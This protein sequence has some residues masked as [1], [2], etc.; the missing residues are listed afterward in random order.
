[1]KAPLLSLNY[2]EPAEEYRN[3]PMLVG[4]LLLFIAVVA[5]GVGFACHLL[6]S[7]EPVG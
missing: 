6:R 3:Q 5:A 1:M 7:D 4:M 2:S